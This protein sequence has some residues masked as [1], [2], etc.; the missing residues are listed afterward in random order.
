F[1]LAAPLAALWLKDAGLDNRL[2]GL[3][4]SVYYFGIALAAPLVPVLMRHCG[5]HCM[6]GGM[7]LDGLAVAL[8]PWASGLAGWFALRFLCGVGTALCL[9]PMETLVNH[10]APPQRRAR[11]F[12]IYATSVALGVGLGPLL[13]LPFYRHAPLATFAGGGLVA[14]VGALLL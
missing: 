6:V 2:A 13:G 3:N 1:G 5:R 11:N 10:A 9:I 7:V 12:G 8:F 14:I 4:T